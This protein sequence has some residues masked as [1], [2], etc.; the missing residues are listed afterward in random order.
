MLKWTKDKPSKDG[1][2]FYKDYHTN[3]CVILLVWRKVRDLGGVPRAA[4]YCEQSRYLASA[5]PSEWAGPIEEPE[6]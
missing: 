4:L 5:M 2:Y 6:E 3:T 1:W